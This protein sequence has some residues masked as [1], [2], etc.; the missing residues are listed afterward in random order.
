MRAD[1]NEAEP[2]VA[3]L[4]QVPQLVEEF[5]ANAAVF[6]LVLQE[7][8]LIEHQRDL[9]VAERRVDTIEVVIQLQ[10]SVL[11]ELAE[12]GRFDGELCLGSAPGDALTD[13]VKEPGG[14]GV[15]EPLAINVDE[16]I[17]VLERRVRQPVEERTLPDPP[18]PKEDEHVV[19]KP[20]AHV[21]ES[22]VEC[23]LAPKK[24]LLVLKWR[25]DD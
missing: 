15:G 21:V 5:G 13:A 2:L 10:E 23:P 19:L 8:I 7:F 22:E 9:L 20:T 18:L 24:D 17:L 16:Q 12:H 4:H 6:G 3:V 25:A 11:D 1:K 14:V